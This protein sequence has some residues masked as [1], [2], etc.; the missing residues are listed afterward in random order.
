M[1]KCA[2]CGEEIGHAG[3]MVHGECVDRLRAQ[4]AESRRRERAAVRCINDIE[5]YLELGSPKYIRA[6][7]DTWRGPS[8]AGEE[9][10]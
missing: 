9:S 1:K 4:L 7:I 10:K 8:E 5:T 6:T 3:H 2:I